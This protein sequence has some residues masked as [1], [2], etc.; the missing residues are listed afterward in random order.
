MARPRKSFKLL[1]ADA[2]N[3]IRDLAAKGCHEATIAKAL[4]ISH[5]TWQK[6]R[7]ETPEFQRALTEGRAIE[8]DVLVSTLMEAATKSK[9][10]TAAIFLLK[11]RHGYKDTGETLVNNKVSITFELPGALQPTVYEAEVLKKS[12]PRKKLKELTCER[13]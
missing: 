11:A 1:P 8:H 7:D 13:T 3:I 6:R 4:G 2:C 9:N 12:I 5:D 10:V